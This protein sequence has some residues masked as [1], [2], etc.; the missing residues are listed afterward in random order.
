LN[1]FFFYK[2]S[3]LNFWIVIFA[4]CA[5]RDNQLREIPSR[6]IGSGRI[7]NRERESESSTGSAGRGWDF[8]E[9]GGN[10]ISEKDDFSSFRGLRERERDERFER[11]SFGREYERGDKERRAPGNRYGR[12]K[13]DEPEWFS[14]G[15]TSQHDTIELHGFDESEIKKKKKQTPASKTKSPGVYYFLCW[16]TNFIAHYFFLVQPLQRRKR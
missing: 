12:H 13:D 10:R 16:L 8:N 2:S 5:N 1:C 6:R 11:R 7:M 14:G 4:S 3:G 15:P 9:R